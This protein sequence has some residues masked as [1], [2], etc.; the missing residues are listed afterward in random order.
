[1][2]LKQA[3]DRTLAA[4]E[5]GDLEGMVEALKARRK[6]LESGEP[7]TLEA[8]EAGERALR[9]LKDLAQHAAFDNARLGQI[10]RY[11]DF[12]R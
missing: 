6:A 5:A 9:A 2:T 7:P 4:I 10:K 8:F 1:M 3:T 11:V 12:R